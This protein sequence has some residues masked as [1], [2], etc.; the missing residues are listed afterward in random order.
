MPE[1]PQGDEEGRCGRSQ[2]LPSCKISTASLGP[3]NF[4]DIF[5][6]VLSSCSVSWNFAHLL[7]PV[8]PLVGLI[9]D[10][11]GGV[12]GSRVVL[13][14]VKGVKVEVEVLVQ[15]VEGVWG[16]SFTHCGLW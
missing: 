12:L 5:L 3:G 15:V 14:F 7:H 6:L 4:L 8:E 2:Q 9:V 11:S 10:I 1:F 16:T 13:V